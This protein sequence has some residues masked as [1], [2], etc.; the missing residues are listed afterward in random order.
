MSKAKPTPRTVR[1]RAL[2]E[3]H[4]QV[5]RDIAAARRVIV[6]QRFADFARINPHGDI[7]DFVA[8]FENTWRSFARPDV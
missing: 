3:L 1:E 2:R 4:N 7:W 8:Q 5:W 6:E